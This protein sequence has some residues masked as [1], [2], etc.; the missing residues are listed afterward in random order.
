MGQ[1]EQGSSTPFQ[2]EEN[3]KKALTELILLHLL[4]KR[5]AYIG[6][7]TAQMQEKSGGAL[8][9]VFPYGAIYRMEKAGYIRELE[10]RIAPDGRRRQYFTITGPGKVYLDQLLSVYARFTKGVHN[11]LDKGEKEDDGLHKEI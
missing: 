10:K 8:S 6:E 1:P 2:L 11:L 7:L 4:S 9:I 5:P 3:L